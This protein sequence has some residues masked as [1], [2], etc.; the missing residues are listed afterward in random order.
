MEFMDLV[1]ERYSVRKFSVRKVEQEK[2]D[3]VL[4]AGRLAPTAVNYQPQRI[5][6]LN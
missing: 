2:V 4:E 1:K 5:L 6:V 3:L